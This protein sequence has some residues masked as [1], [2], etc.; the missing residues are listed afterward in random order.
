MQRRIFS[1]ITRLTVEDIGHFQSILGPANVIT[2]P[3]ELAPLNRDWT[4]QFTGHSR[5]ALRPANTREVSLVLQYCNQRR[6]PLVPQ[7]GNTGLVG[8]GVPV[9]DEVILGMG[10]MNRLRSF[11]PAS[12]IVQVEA[13]CILANL[14]A[15]LQAHH[16]AIFPVDLGAKG[17]CQ[18]GGMLATNAGINRMCIID[19]AYIHNHLRILGGL[20]VLRYGGMRA[21]TI[22]LEAVLADGT[23]LEGLGIGGSHRKDNTGYD[24]GQLLVG[25]EGTLAVITAAAL[26]T[27]PMPR[28]T[29]LALLLLQDF[30]AVGEVLRTSKAVLGEI[31]SAF[32]FWDA[33]AHGLLEKHGLAEKHLFKQSPANCHFLLLIETRGGDVEHDRSKMERLMDRLISDGHIRDGIL[34]MDDSQV[35]RLWAMRES[36]PEA[37]AREGDAVL[38]Y[39]VSLPPARMYELVRVA[40]ER[41]Q[42]TQ[43]TVIGYGH[44]GDGNL[45]LNVAVRGSPGAIKGRLEPFIYEQVSRMAGSISAEHGIGQLKS[46]HLHYSKPAPMIGLMRRVKELFDPRG[47]LNP[48]KVLI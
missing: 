41:L 45:H 43:T 42:D 28:A 3:E 35:A 37:C 46:I 11:D 17:S 47:I 6:L 12:G 48:H 10:R 4:N 34:A 29:H 8:G 21:N 2:D 1:N 36:I 38:K 18:I 40:Q 33:P 22:S 31:L 7:G 26:L 27:A 16:Q 30:E 9:Q 25:S 19:N 23:V 5:V 32:E 15:H 13:G 24:L 20:R 44:V 39:D 14:D